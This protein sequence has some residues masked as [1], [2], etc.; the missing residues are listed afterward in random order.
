MATFWRG[1]SLMNGVVWT[2]WRDDAEGYGAYPCCICATKE[3][4]EIELERFVSVAGFPREE[5]SIEEEPVL[6]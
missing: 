3:R 2:V 4:A 1:L 6:E 5:L